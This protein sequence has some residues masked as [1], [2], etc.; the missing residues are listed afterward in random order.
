MV[1]ETPALADPRLEDAEYV[2]VR[3]G[4]VR[5]LQEAAEERGVPESAVI[6]TMV[7][8]VSDD[9]YVFVLVP[10][11]RVIDWAKLRQALGVNRLS[12]PD[13][14]TAL[15]ATGYARGAITPFGASRDLPVIADTRLA[16][17][18]VSIG[19]GA[20]GVSITMSGDDAVRLLG[21]SLSDVTKPGQPPNPRKHGSGR[22]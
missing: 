21:A 16:G 9:E 3:H 1:E 12:L 6:K 22:Q 20:R 2:V 8:R 10:G 17:N 5:S 11:D 13:E 14:K 7:I 4:P 18:I 15:A 19:G